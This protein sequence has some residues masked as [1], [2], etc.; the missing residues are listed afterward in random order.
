MVRFDGFEERSKTRTRKSVDL[1]FFE[2][3]LRRICRRRQRARNLLLPGR[4]H[5]A[6]RLPNLELRI[7]LRV[8]IDGRDDLE[9]IGRGKLREFGQLL[10]DLF[11]A[12]NRERAGGVDEIELGI[13]VEEDG[14]HTSSM[15]LSLS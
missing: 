9:V 11:C 7:I 13:Y 6:M 12:G 4:S 2:N 8:G 10:Q 15:A 14:L 3:D 1:L 5:D